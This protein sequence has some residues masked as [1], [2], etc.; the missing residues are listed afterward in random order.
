MSVPQANSSTTSLW[1]VRDG[2]VVQVIAIDGKSVAVP[3]AA[4][5]KGTD[6]AGDGKG[7][8]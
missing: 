3:A 4:K 7:A 6:K 5:D 8:R 2:S 1:P